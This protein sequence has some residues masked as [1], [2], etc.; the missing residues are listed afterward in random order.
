MES[1]DCSV[2]TR[3]TA[4]QEVVGSNPTHGGNNISVVHSITMFTQAIQ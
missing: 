4:D 1:G 2:E 3:W